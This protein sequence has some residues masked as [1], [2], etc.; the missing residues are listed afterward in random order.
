MK[1][2]QLKMSTLLLN[3]ISAVEL[4]Q[5][6]AA[7]KFIS[8]QEVKEYLLNISSSLF[9]ISSLLQVCRKSINGKYNYGNYNLRKS[10]ALCFDGLNTIADEL[11]RGK[12]TFKK[13]S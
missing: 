2:L 10:I 9:G 5:H 3:S 13:V 6:D 11:E 7:E 1:N 8:E 12:N 4:K